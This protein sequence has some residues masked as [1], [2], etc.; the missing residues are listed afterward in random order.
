MKAKEEA[1]T[2]VE[3]ERRS[4]EEAEANNKRKLEA[5][6]LKIEIDFQRHKDDLLRLEQ[7]LSHLKQSTQSAELHQQSNTLRTGACEGTKAQRE[8]KIAKLFQLQELEKVVNVSEKE[9]NSENSERICIICKKDE[10]SIVLL[11]CAHQVMCASCSGEYRR[12]GK[13]ACPCCRVS[14]QQ[15][16]RVFGATS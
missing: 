7:E 11:P 8:K 10:V 12:N 3:E 6:R 5:L 15:M 14:I 16:I 9:D 1:L 13:T 4:K 2:L